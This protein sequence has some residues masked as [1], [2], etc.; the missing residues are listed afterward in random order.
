MI[1]ETEFLSLLSQYDVVL[2][3]YEVSPVALGRSQGEVINWGHTYLKTKEIY[4]ITKGQGVAIAIL[5]TAGSFADHPDLSQNSLEAFAK[6]FTNSSTSEDLHGHGTH[7]GGIAAA[8]DN[9]IGIIGVAPGASLIPIKVL[10][11]QGAG[12]YSWI[13]KGIKYIADLNIPGVKHKVISMSLG[14]GNGSTNLQGAIQYAIAKGCYVV[15]A[16]GNSYRGSSINSMNYPARYNE[17]IA[18]GSINK[19][20]QPSSFSSAG[21]ELD[22]A[23]PGEAIYSTHKGKTYAYLSGTSMATPFVAGVV[24]LLSAGRSDLKGQTVM[25]KHLRD[26]SKDVFTPGF[27]NRTGFG[28]PFLPLVFGTPSQPSP[29][30][31]PPTQPPT[32]PPTTQPPTTQPPTPAPPAPISPTPV[33]DQ[34]N[35]NFAIDGPFTVVWQPENERSRNSNMLT[36]NSAE[37]DTSSFTSRS[38]GRTLTITRLEFTVGSKLLAETEYDIAKDHFQWFFTSRGFVLEANSDFSDAV[39]WTRHFLQ[40]LLKSRKRYTIKVTYIHGKDERGRETFLTA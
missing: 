14:G 31:A 5:D 35:L 10:N 1:N 21:P 30:P 18:V 33:K 36:F 38:A 17:V 8:V 23:A 6:N 29:P 28:V 13:A 22:I 39:H 15:A 3:P 2:P 32:Q 40:V 9:N 16:A 34:R 11:D 26:N 24:A 4:G 20:S 25:H 19:Q 12:S 27:D 37:V 7:C